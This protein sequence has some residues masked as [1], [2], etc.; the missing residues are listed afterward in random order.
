MSRNGLHFRPCFRALTVC[1]LRIRT[2][3]HVTHLHRHGNV[4]SQHFL[5]T[6]PKKQTSKFCQICSSNHSLKRVLV[7]LAE[8]LG[9]VYMDFTDLLNRGLFTDKRTDVWSWDFIHNMKNQFWAVVWAGLWN[10]RAWADYEQLL[11]PVFSLFQGKK[12]FF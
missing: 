9:F 2:L 11:R 3:D 8:L 6:D 1:H 4:F 7:D 10:K 12:N 5:C